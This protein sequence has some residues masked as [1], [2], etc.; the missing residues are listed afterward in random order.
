[1][2]KKEKFLLAGAVAVAAVVGIHM[3]D[4]EQK[5]KEAAA[6]PAHHKRKQAPAPDFSNPNDAG[7]QSSST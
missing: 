5:R 2:R 1:M 3:I 4:K 6:P 7:G